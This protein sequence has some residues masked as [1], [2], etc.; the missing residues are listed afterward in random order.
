[1]LAGRFGK[2]AGN[3]ARL[4]E[5]LGMAERDPLQRALAYLDA[6]VLSH[7]GP[8]RSERVI[9]GQ[10]RRSRAARAGNNPEG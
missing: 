10:N 1:M 3:S 4:E 8:H 6:V 7:F 2:N 9:G 5:G